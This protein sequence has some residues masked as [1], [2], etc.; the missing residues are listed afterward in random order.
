MVRPHFGPK[1]I[2]VFSEKF[3]DIRRTRKLFATYLEFSYLR[4]NMMQINWKI[5]G[6]EENHMEIDALFNFDD[7]NRAK[8]SVKNN[9]T[10]IPDTGTSKQ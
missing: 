5:L 4:K 1:E 10:F 8:K 6:I 2:F 7:D 9:R 3:F